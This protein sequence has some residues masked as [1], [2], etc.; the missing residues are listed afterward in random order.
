MATVDR[1]A[2]WRVIELSVCSGRLWAHGIGHGLTHAQALT[3]VREAVV[4]PRRAVACGSPHVLT[5]T[6][7]LNVASAGPSA[8]RLAVWLTDY[9]I[10]LRAKG[11]LALGELRA[12]AS[13]PLGWIARLPRPLARY[14]EGVETIWSEDFE[15]LLEMDQRRRDAVDMMERVEP[16]SVAGLLRATPSWDPFLEW[17]AVR[18]ALDRIDVLRRSLVGARQRNEEERSL[19]SATPSRSGLATCTMDPDGDHMREV[20]C[21]ALFRTVWC[22]GPYRFL[23][24]N[25]FNQGDDPVATLS[26]RL[27]GLVEM[28]LDGPISASVTQVQAVAAGLAGNSMKACSRC[29]TIKGKEAFFDPALKGG[30]GGY[31]RVCLACK[32]KGADISFKTTTGLSGAWRSRSGK[33]RRWR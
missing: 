10:G 26:G 23:R 32:E 2:A 24:I 29:G 20:G 15:G 8:S 17:V 25:R 21:R 33:R 31:G 27:Y 30:V 11:L 13:I 19:A 3:H 1:H 18:A 7:R 9:L 5:M 14:F 4:E 22:G 6:A 16:M 12:G 28:A